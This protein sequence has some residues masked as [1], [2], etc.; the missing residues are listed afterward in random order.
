MDAKLKEV[1]DWA[2]KKIAQGTEP[3]WAWKRYMDLIVLLNEIIASRT[4]TISLEDSLRLQVHQE[5]DH[6]LPAGIRH[7]DTARR[8]RAVLRARLPM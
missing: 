7:I 2:E 6:P 4:A 1:L 5:P 8:R 3:P